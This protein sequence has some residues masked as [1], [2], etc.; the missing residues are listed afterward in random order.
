MTS[1]SEYNL[2]KGVILAQ[3]QHDLSVAQLATRLGTSRMQIYRYREA[4]DLK[5]SKVCLL[6]DTFGMSLENFLELCRR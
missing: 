4:R 6:A 5:F 2:G 1:R 3:E